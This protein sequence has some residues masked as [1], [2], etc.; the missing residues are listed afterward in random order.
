M[1]ARGLLLGSH[2][3]PARG[4]TIPLL[5]QPRGHRPA[6]RHQH[7]RAADRTG[8]RASSRTRPRG[9]TP[10]AA[11]RAV[12][13][14]RYRDD[15]QP[16]GDLERAEHL[17][18]AGPEGPV[19]GAAQAA[20]TPRSRKVDPDALV[21]GCSTA[22]IDRKFIRRMLDLGAPF[23]ILTIHPYRTTLDDRAFV[24]DLER[25]ADLV[26]LPDGR[27]REVWITEMGWA[28]NVPHNTL[29][30][31]FQPVT[32]R[33]Q[34]ELLARA[35]LDAIASG[36]APN[37]SWYDFR[38]DGTDPTNFEHNLGIVSRN[39]APKPAYRAWRPW[40]SSSAVHGRPITRT[41]GATSSPT[42]SGMPAASV[43]SV[44]CGASKPSRQ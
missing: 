36:V 1:V 11:G 33:R 42:G 6:A 10:T 44:P 7:L 21:L 17:L 40:R 35:Y 8:G 25:A 29:G 43:P 26:R 13:V 34:A 23:D 39:F 5:R 37:I 16:L 3:A 22:G 24:I 20:P 19:R 41:S 14:D 2:R 28:T 38:N 15:V 32:Q 27:R 4:V 9:S 30:Q 12:V 18:L 31:D